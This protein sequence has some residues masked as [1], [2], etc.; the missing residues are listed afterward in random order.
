MV[1]SNLD[2]TTKEL[3]KTYETDDMFQSRSY[4]DY[5]SINGHLYSHTGTVAALFFVGDLYKV[6]DP[7]VKSYKYVLLVG[8]SQQCLKDG[9][10]NEAKLLLSEKSDILNETASLNAKT[11]PI[12]VIE[13][14]N[15]N[16]DS[17]I[18]PFLLNLL[19]INKREF[20]NEDG[21]FRGFIDKNLMYMETGTL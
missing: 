6:Y 11:D 12:A 2:W 20:L 19:A 5:A 16:F 7:S 18:P 17:I 13:I 9:T 15:E 8:R 14:S 21:G 10:S 4:T 3:V 1:L